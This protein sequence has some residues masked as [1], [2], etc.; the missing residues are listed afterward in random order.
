ML[1]LDLTLTAR[2]ALDECFRRGLVVQSERELAGRAGSRHWH[3]RKPG[4]PGTLELNEWQNRV[5]V[6][7]HPLRDGGWATA[8]AKE[9]ATH[10][11]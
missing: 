11:D 2:D 4:C 8:C 9:L 5:W 7:V 6:K 3:L 10:G 1:E